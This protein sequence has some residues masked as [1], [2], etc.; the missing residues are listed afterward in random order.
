MAKIWTIQIRLTKDQFERIKNY[1]RMKG[2]ASMSGYLRFVA[3]DHDFVLQQ[4]I[5]EIHDHLLGNKNN[6]KFKK[7]HSINSLI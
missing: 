1:S 2:F 4:K 6:D 7:N 3:L 5:F